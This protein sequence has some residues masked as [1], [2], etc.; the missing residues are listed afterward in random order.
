MKAHHIVTSRGNDLGVFSAEDREQA[1][2]LAM[3]ARLELL[4]HL[5]G[6]R[7][8]V[9]ARDGITMGI[10]G[11]QDRH[12]HYE[13]RVDGGIRTIVEWQNI[14]VTHVDCTITYRR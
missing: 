6:E 13:V 1:R 12:G 2:Y 9:I 4:D 3:E 8:G 7:V 11:E 14:V 5:H 10:L